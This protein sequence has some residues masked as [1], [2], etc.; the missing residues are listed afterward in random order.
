[1]NVVLFANSD[2]SE[3]F[4]D[5]R[6]YLK[7]ALMAS[8]SFRVNFGI[9]TDKSSRNWLIACER[10]RISAFRVDKQRPEIRLGANTL[11]RYAVYY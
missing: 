7:T 1:M 10:R 3:V 11:Y 9:S 6:K 5:V 2:S 4:G 8:G